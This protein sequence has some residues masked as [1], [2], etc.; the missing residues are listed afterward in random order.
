LRSIRDT[1]THFILK[2]FA[3]FSLIPLFIIIIRCRG[4]LTRNF[5]FCTSVWVK[6]KKGFCSF[7]VGTLL[8]SNGNVADVCRCVYVG[9]SV[10]PFADE[11]AYP[12]SLSSA[13]GA[14]GGGGEG[15]RQQI[16]RDFLWISYSK[17]RLF[18]Y[19]KFTD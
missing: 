2:P 5:F 14:G 15:T 1:T 8:I 11:A 4:N 9:C 12:L 6:I 13:R 17:Q 7:Y 19:T 3:W 18:P 10:L 16:W